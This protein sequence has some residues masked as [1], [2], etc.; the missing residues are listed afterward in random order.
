MGLFDKKDKYNIKEEASV[1]EFAQP[2]DNISRE[3]KNKVFEAFVGGYAAPS[4]FYYINKVNEE[5]EFRYGFSQSGVKIFNNPNNKDLHIIKHNK[6]FYEDFKNNLIQLTKDWSKQ[7]YYDNQI[8][9]GTQ[10]NIDIDIENAITYSGSNAFPKDFNK[11]MNYIDDIFETKKSN[12]LKKYEIDSE[13]NVLQK[14]YDIPNLNN[15]NARKCPYCGSTE[16]WK[17]LYGEPAYDY[18]KDK[19]V[20]GGCEITGNQPTYKCKNCGK[21][22]YP[23]NNF[24]KLSNNKLSKESIRIGIKNEKNNYVLILNHVNNSKMYDI[25][26]ADLNNLEG[27]AISDLSTNLPEKYYSQFV[28]KLYSIIKDWQN[29]YSGKSNIVWSINYDMENNK[30]LI[31]GNGGF[32]SNWNEFIDLISEYEKIFKNKK[33]IDIEKIHDMEYDKLSFTEVVN[34]KL[35]DPFWAELVIKYFKEEEQVNDFDGKLLFKD[36]SKYDDILNEFIKCLNQRTYDLKDAIEIN[37]YTAKK[38]HELNPD[39]EVCGVYNFMKTLRDDKEFAEKII[40][41]GFPNKDAVPPIFANNN[42][43]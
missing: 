35:K 10:W 2:E 6:K 31:S 13:Q 32:P 38:I 23:D 28:S 22:V 41:S 5:Y 18:D 30:K 43:D 17:Y 34:G 25:V 20:L 27:K 36:L 1:P 7:G 33:K 21:D 39:F 40:K 9:D 16:L 19:Y 11:V 24:I 3:R 26:F 12:N 4:S 8:M 14:V 29:I 15:I 42:E 37:G